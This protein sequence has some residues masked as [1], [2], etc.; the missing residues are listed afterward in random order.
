MKTTTEIEFKTFITEEKYSE[1]LKKFDM[2]NNIL[3]QTNH[4]FDTDD[5]LFEKEKKVLRIRQKGDQYKLTK[6]SKGDGCN[7]ENHVY[8]EK[9]NAIDMIKNGFNAKMIDEDVFVRKVGTLT[10]YRTKI[11]YKNGFLFL[12]KSEYNGI[13]DFELEYEADDKEAGEKDFHEILNEFNIEYKPSISK[14]KR[15]MTTKK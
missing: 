8:L 12:D 6:K 4:Y 3:I 13:I 9:G 2:V 15:C 7:I 5:N 11:Q 10:T 1:L 14:F